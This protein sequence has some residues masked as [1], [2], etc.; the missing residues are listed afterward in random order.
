[1]HLWKDILER[2]KNPY[3]VIG[4]V[5]CLVTIL[6]TFGLAVNTED[7]KIVTD[8]FCTIFILLGIMNNPKTKGL[9]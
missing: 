1:M 3:T 2:F 5:A 8:S 4:V 7:A 6:N 9:S